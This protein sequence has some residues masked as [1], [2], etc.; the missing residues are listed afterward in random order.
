MPRLGWGFGVDRGH[1]REA[2]VAA[3]SGRNEAMQKLAYKQNA[4][5]LPWSSYAVKRNSIEQ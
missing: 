3:T 4:L 1:L 2:A 5:A